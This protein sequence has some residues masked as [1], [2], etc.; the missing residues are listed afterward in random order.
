MKINST[1]PID[2]LVNGIGMWEPHEQYDARMAELERR[3][4]LAAKHDEL[5][6]ALVLISYGD[7][8]S[9]PAR[10]ERYNSRTAETHYYPHD[11]TP[12]GIAAAIIKAAREVEP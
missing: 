6:R 3:S 9:F 12:D 2:Q 10:V 1:T 8:D 11:G 7:I 5:T 4:D